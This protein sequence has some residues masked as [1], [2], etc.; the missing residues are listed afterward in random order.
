[1]GA[2]YLTQD[3]V[4]TYVLRRAEWRREYSGQGPVTD[5]QDRI[6]IDP[7]IDLT[8]VPRLPSPN[9]E[10]TG[11]AAQL[12]SQRVSINDSSRFRAEIR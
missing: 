5:R 8:K 12:R 2:Y 1:M 4:W 7:S 9:S 11:T 10:G 3:S 6:G